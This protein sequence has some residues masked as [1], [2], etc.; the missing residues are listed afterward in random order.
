[1]YK[2]QDLIYKL[3]AMREE[4]EIDLHIFVDR[5]EE[6]FNDAL[7]EDVLLTIQPDQHRNERCL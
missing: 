6:D 2:S 1:M 5:K 4:R 7:N 3:I